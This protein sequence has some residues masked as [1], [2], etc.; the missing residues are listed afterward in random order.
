MSAAPTRRGRWLLAAAAAVVL[1]IFLL[2]AP[3]RT[4]TVGGKWLIVWKRGGLLPEAGGGPWPMLHRRRLLGS[5]QVDELV[6]AHNYIGDDCVVYITFHSER[7]GLWAACG[8]HS[9]IA[10]SGRESGIDWLTKPQFRTDPVR[11]SESTFVSV[12]EIKRRA[13]ASR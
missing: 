5:R 9:P 13:N 6:E 1:L 12:A 10:L 3:A 2:S 4:E 11:V 7:T 8:D